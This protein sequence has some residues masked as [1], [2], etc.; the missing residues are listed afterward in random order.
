MKLELVLLD[1]PQAGRR[2]P[3][4]SGPVSFGRSAEAMVS[5]PQDSFL[6]GMHLTVEAVAEGVQLVDPRSTNGTFLN[7]ERVSRAIAAVGDVIKIGSLTMQVAEARAAG[8]GPVFSSP[9][10]PVAP[11]AIE[12]PV[13]TTAPLNNK[14]EGVLDVLRL[15]QTP[16]FCLL[17]AA[18]DEMIPSFLALVQEQVPMQCL[19]DGR[20]A[21]TLSRWAPYLVQLS[22]T[23]PLLRVILEKGWGKGW[24]SYFTSTAPFEELRKHFRKFLMVQLEEGKEVYFRFYDPRVLRD[25]LPT[26]NGGE[27]AM[28]FGPVTEWMIEAEDSS[29]LLRLRNTASGLTSSLVKVDGPSGMTQVIRIP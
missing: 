7:G 4:G 25:F 1:G 2:L 29:H 20:S 23:A 26:A 3:L 10:A 22:P 5:F 12:P 6:S 15:V 17:D 18:A 13:S 28:F 21:V 19:Y 9:P 11:K 24:A 8:S 14:L 27:L 16:L